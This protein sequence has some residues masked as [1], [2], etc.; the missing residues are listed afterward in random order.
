[1]NGSRG[2]S[3]NTT[4]LSLQNKRLKEIREC[5]ERSKYTP[6]QRRDERKKSGNS[7]IEMIRRNGADEAT[8]ARMAQS[9]AA[10]DAMVAEV[11]DEDPHKIYE[12]T[13]NYGNPSKKITIT[14]EGSRHWRKATDQDVA[15]IVYIPMQ[16]QFG[17]F[18]DTDYESDEEFPEVKI[19]TAIVYTFSGEQRTY[20]AY[21]DKFG[22]L[23]IV[24]DEVLNDVRNEA[25]PGRFFS[26]QSKNGNEW[27]P[28]PE[29]KV[30]FEHPFLKEPNG[31]YLDDCSYYCV[32]RQIECP[33]LYP[34]IIEK[35]WREHGAFAYWCPVLQRFITEGERYRLQHW[36]HNG[37]GSAQ[38]RYYYDQNEMLDLHGG[39]D[40]L[41][42]TVSASKDKD[43]D[44]EIDQDQK[45][46][47]KKQRTK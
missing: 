31:M 4:N 14:S 45:M 20:H 34:E 18:D 11:P 44:S 46:P 7:V 33:G 29:G 43:E 40:K 24:P 32:K 37:D 38:Q 15:S 17:E 42:T 28:A 25:P 36:F 8:I 23:L 6:Q 5:Y 10:V 26:G 2:D 3:D 1:M 35:Q 22:D 41:P 13:F 16:N 21:D 39:L 30:W 9:I 19:P 27:N 47:A 12:Q